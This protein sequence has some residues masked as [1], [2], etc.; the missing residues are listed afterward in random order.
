M[1]LFHWAPQASGWSLGGTK[2]A[3]TYTCD[4]G[5]CGFGHRMNIILDAYLAVNKTLAVGWG[6]CG[7]DVSNIFGELFKATPSIKPNLAPYDP[8]NTDCI[9]EDVKGQTPYFYSK[10]GIA[11][12]DTLARNLNP[13][14]Q[15]RVDQFKA[16]VNWDSTPVIGFY[17]R[18]GN[19]NRSLASEQPVGDI[20]FVRKGRSLGNDST[21]FIRRHLEQLKILAALQGYGDDYRIFLATDEETIQDVFM[22]E[23]GPARGIVRPQVRPF[24]IFSRR[25]NPTQGVRV[26]SH[27]GPIRCRECGYILMM[28]QSDAGSLYI[29]SSSGTP[30]SHSL[31]LFAAVIRS[32]CGNLYIALSSFIP[33]SPR[34]SRGGL[35]GVYRGGL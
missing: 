26:Y 28:D 8:P 29:A 25:T 23:A 18:A 12:L 7:D 34:G 2:V 6:L 4:F 5:C 27:H 3:S 31:L 13:S 14:M 19:L 9:R 22:R 30:N 16:D 15:E 35:E 24:F 20:D 11:L 17:V 10:R 32:R 21:V 1:F 33:N